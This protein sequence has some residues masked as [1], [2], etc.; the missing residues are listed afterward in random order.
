MRGIWGV[1]LPCVTG[2]LQ[3]RGPCTCMGGTWR[4]SPRGT[5]VEGIPGVSGEPSTQCCGWST[6]CHSGCGGRQSCEGKA[7]LLANPRIWIFSE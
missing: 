2:G 7:F 3:W 6:G 1:G 5:Q 4:E